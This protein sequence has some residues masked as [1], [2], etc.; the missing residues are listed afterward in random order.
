[1][2]V[3][4]NPGETMTRIAICVV[5]LTA[6][7]PGAGAALARQ[8]APPDGIMT[9]YAGTPAN[10]NFI[11]DDTVVREG[12]L[13]RFSNFRV[14]AEPIPSPAGAV[15]MDVQAVTLD[16][17]ARTAAIGGIETFTS[18][19]APVRAFPGEPTAPIEA[20]STWGFAAQVLCDGVVLPPTQKRTGWQAAR[21]VALMMMARAA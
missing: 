19:G 5:A 7:L 18:A 20:R 6:V 2:P 16:C 17:G 9:L 15:G 13:V 1:M 8:A 4:V 21:E 14:Y 10:A 3:W 11:M 12:S